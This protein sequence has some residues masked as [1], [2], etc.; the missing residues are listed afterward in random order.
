[1]C[2]NEK[3]KIFSSIITDCVQVL[4]HLRKKEEISNKVL[5]A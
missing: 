1:M 5:L 3:T 2:R 4:E